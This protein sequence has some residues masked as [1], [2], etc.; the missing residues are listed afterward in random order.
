MSELDVDYSLS[1]GGRPFN[2]HSVEGREALSE[3]S[4][5]RVEVLL[6]IGDG[7]EPDDVS[8]TECELSIRRGGSPVRTLRL[9]A[10]Q[11]ERHASAD[12]DNVGVPLEI[13]L[14][15][16][17]ALLAYRTDIRIFRDL[18]VPTIVTK[19]LSAFGISVE[20]RLSQSYAIRPYTVQWRESDLAFVSRLLEDEGIYY[21]AKA[22]GGILLGDSVAAYDDA[23]A[24]AFVHRG[25]LDPARESITGAGWTG[26]MTPSTVT[27]RDFD[28]KRPRLDV[29]GRAT[30]GARASASGGEH[31]VYPAA[32]LDPDAAAKK[33]RYA[34]EAFA[35]AQHRLSGSATRL[36]LAP[37]GR[38]AIR[39]LPD[40][41]SDGSYAVVAVEHRWDQTFTQV[42]VGFEA[43]DAA[44]TFRPAPVTPRPS[45]V[46][47]TVG[48]V[49]GPAGED[50]HTDE[51]GRAKVH[52]HW[53]R[54][55]PKDDRCSDWIPTLQDNTGHSIGIPRVGWEMMVQHLE[56]DPDRPVI[57]GRVYTPADDFYAKLPDNKMYSRL[58]SLT[59]PR[60]KDEDNGYNAIEFRDLKDNEHIRFHAQR[61]QVVLT[62]HDRT[63]TTLERDSRIVEGHETI[64]VGKSRTHHVAKTAKALVGTDQTVSIGGNRRL[65]VGGRLAD[66]T[67]KDRK[68]TIG[69]AHL[70]RLEALDDLHAQ[71]DLDETVGALNLEISKDSN[72]SKTTMAEALLVGGAIL[73]LAKQ[74]LTQGVEKLHLEL[75]G[76]LLHQEA[77][78]HIGIRAS[79][80][81][82][83]TVGGNYTATSGTAV[84][85]SGI[86]SL[87][88]TVGELAI[89]AKKK[90]TLK[91]QDTTLI[92]EKDK[93]SIDA[94]N[95]ITA[96]ADGEN[97]LNADR[98]GQ[99]DRALGG[100]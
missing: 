93:H 2:A 24:L 37:N 70:R 53:D 54:L 80:K 18:D 77:K 23:G 100:A 99:N 68:L 45:L 91:V 36:T 85:L 27:M 64:K 14:R 29:V 28:F 42:E 92:L 5:F 26:H 97:D 62:E 30:V 66:T 12:R 76:A 94:P 98:S 65:T 33:A 73:E 40:G 51:W 89:A 58:G 71:K 34:A 49:T 38:I 39:E 84:L 56:G 63:E 8:G 25:G 57:L 17:I 43:I 22:D 13:E 47:A 83:T 3:P 16:P 82:T 4:R 11:V 19:V 6:P 20:R 9:Q 7:L 31:Y 90:L 78:E 96:H 74:G 15:S 87:K 55:Q 1:V 79:N 95:E 69:G 81:R 35:A 41:L 86:E 52:F 67:T 21:V 50:I 48:T 59:S 10:F 32:R 72:E 60:S 88:M 61:D 75:V 46:G 44:Q